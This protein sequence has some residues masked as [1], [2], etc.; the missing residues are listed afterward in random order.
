MHHALLQPD[1][2]KAG[3]DI[4]AIAAL[5]RE[6]APG[7]ISDIDVL[8]VLR[9]LRNDTQGIGLLEQIIAQ[10]G[11]TDILVNGTGEIWFERGYG[12]ELSDLQF[13]HPSQIRQ[14]ATR[15]AYYRW[16]PA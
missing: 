6:K 5:I 11:V 3:D 10:D 15:F 16:K 14:L 4:A 8:S 2:T 13:D 1:N 12:L 9:T 7:V